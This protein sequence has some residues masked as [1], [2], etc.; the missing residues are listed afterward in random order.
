M[1]VVETSSVA[2]GASGAR[3]LRLRPRNDRDPVISREQ[4][5]E[6]LDR[7]RPAVIAE[8]HRAFPSLPVQEIEN[9]YGDACADALE[10]RFNEVAELAVYVRQHVH[11][12]AITLKNSPGVARRVVVAVE[13]ADRAPGP[14]E[15]TVQTELVALLH[16][17]IAEQS[18][19]DRNVVWLL[20]NGQRPA[21]IARALGVSRAGATADCKRL[22]SSLERFVA[23]QTRPAAICAR[24]R[25]DVLSWQQTGRM[26]LALRWHLRWHHS[27]A[28]AVHDTREAAE[29]ALLPLVPAAAALPHVGLV[30]RALRAILTNRV[31]GAAH[32]GLA[33]VRRLAPAGG[34]SAAAGAGAIKAVAIIG[35]GV[36]AVHAIT[37]APAHHSHRA[38]PGIVARAASDTTT[39]PV[40]TA[41][42]VVTMPTPLPRTIE[43]TTATVPAT[44]ATASTAPVAPDSGASSPPSSAGSATTTTEPAQQASSPIS[45]AGDASSTSAPSAGGDGG[46]GPSFEGGGT[47]PP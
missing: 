5:A 19:H 18:G 7:L 17:F 40:S 34:G 47:P 21:Q 42:I 12:R 23:L 46:T 39:T 33:R 2:D 37:A 9:L 45:P 3:E 44:P 26:P 43:S 27:C 30:G 15:Q 32:D 13:R 36:A 1:T 35:A 10:R 29:Q 24:R 31:T 16:E 20:A 25:D 22:R 41:P 8:K 11:N 28:L 6:A 38:R 4:L 14:Y